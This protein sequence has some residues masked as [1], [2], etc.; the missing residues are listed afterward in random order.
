MIEKIHFKLQTLQAAENDN[1]Q[2]IEAKRVRQRTAHNTMFCSQT[3]PLS[4][5]VFLFCLES[6]FLPLPA[7]IIRTHVAGQRRR[8]AAAGVLLTD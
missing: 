2:N 8:Y 6:P 3:Y 5:T 1:T 4:L 7:L